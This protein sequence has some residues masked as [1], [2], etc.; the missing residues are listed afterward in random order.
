QAVQLL[1]A[2]TEERAQR[3]VR[4]RPVTVS[5]EETDA[6]RRV[7]VRLAKLPVR[8]DEG[9]LRLLARSHVEARPDPA[10]HV[11]VVV[12]DRRR[13]TLDPSNRP[14]RVEE[15]VLDVRGSTEAG[16]LRPLQLDTRR[17]EGM[18]RGRPAVAQRPIGLEPGEL[19]PAVVDVDAAAGGV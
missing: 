13:V 17:V 18:E 3:P 1:L 6:D 4:L 11:P 14:V 19:A 2:V 12:L 8:L 10:C 7:V 15:P 16:R 5:G 9:R